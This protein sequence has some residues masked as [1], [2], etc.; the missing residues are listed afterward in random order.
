VTG[1][2]LAPRETV[3]AL[4]TKYIATM[5]YRA[6]KKHPLITAGVVMGTLF[7]AAAAQEGNRKD[8]S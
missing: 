5:L 7:L 4:I 1:L 8:Y 3:Q 6:I 2:I